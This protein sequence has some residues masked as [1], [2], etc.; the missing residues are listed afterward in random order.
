M[1][2]TD[3]A[4]PIVRALRW[5]RDLHPDAPQRVWLKPATKSGGRSAM[6]SVVPVTMS[7]KM[8]PFADAAHFLRL[9]ALDVLVDALT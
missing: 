8:S 3:V 7:W 4:C 2:G 6:L 1:L 5:F 9:Q